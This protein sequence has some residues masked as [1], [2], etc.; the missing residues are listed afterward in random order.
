MNE[1]IDD[2]QITRADLESFF[3][4]KAFR[5]II[6]ADS[7]TAFILKALLSGAFF[8][9]FLLIILLLDEI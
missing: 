2:H 9:L 6:R 8:L 1:K 3:M 4:W 7:L 5:K